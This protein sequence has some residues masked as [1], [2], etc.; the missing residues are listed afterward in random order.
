VRRNQADGEGSVRVHVAPRGCWAKLAAEMRIQV[1][2]QGML[3]R[4]ET[5]DL[6]LELFLMRQLVTLGDY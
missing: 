3:L 4:L 5:R 1:L 2:I 6:A